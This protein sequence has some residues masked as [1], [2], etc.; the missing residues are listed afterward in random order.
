M[1]ED[2]V[3]STH[4]QHPPT[5]EDD[6][7][8]RL[9]LLRSR[10]VGIST[11]QRLMREH[12]SAA[13][14][15]E[16]LPDVAR[17]AGLEAYTP[18][19]LSVAE[20][21]LRNGAQAQARLVWQGERDYPAALLDLEDAPPCLWVK[22]HIRLVHR[23]SIAL[24]GARNASSLGTRM[25]RHLA[26]DLGKEGYVIV[27]G[28]ARGVDTAAHLAALKSG[29]I[30]VFAGGIDVVYPSENARLAADIAKGGL[31]ITEQ[32]PGMTPVA[33]HF[34]AR[35][36][37]ISGLSRA[38]VVVEA[39]MRSGSLVAA[40]HAL[41]QGREILSVPG[42]P[43]EPRAAGCNF[44]IRD[45]AKL[46]RSAEDILEAL[47]PLS[48]PIGEPE[49]PLGSAPE[50]A[51]PARH[52]TPH[53]EATGAL[54]SEILSRLDP[55]PMAEDVLIRKIGLPAGRVTQ[56]IT[57]LELDGLVQRETGGVLRRLT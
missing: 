45:G 8:D 54:H 28:L 49:L 37:L 3:S 43:L 27:S 5:T 56:E 33:R 41:D 14:A 52:E 18:C 55:A 57:D 50:H 30:A 10:R 51:P 32:P 22:G 13:N 42:H 16:A 7:L 53:L 24:V 46:V 48:E 29:T 36:R 39:A 19:P 31:V 34:P 15:L 44:L 6:R 2:K 38:M 47:S 4:P 25:A 26:K 20:T 21:E 9:R 1:A 17:A 23:P 12:G 35:N 11:Y 40:R